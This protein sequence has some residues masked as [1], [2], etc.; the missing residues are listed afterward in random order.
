MANPFL[1]CLA[2][3]A[4][5]VALA[6]QPRLS[7][8]PPQA[9]YVVEAGLGR[10]V[11]W[12]E[13]FQSCITPRFDQ[14]TKRWMTPRPELNKTQS[15]M[16]R[17]RHDTDI[18]ALSQAASSG[19]CKGGTVL[20]GDSITERWNRPSFSKKKYYCG[21]LQRLRHCA[22]ASSRCADFRHRRRSNP[23]LGLAA[24]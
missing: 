5:V 14:E 8:L 1:A 11:D 2:A 17:Q 6:V 16:W 12:G 4:S 9:K 7:P 23:G 13:G 18:L 10:C 19:A 22:E 15:K 20:L 21:E 3:L 24:F